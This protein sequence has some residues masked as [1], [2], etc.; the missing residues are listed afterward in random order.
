MSII[1]KCEGALVTVTMRMSCQLSLCSALVPSCLHKSK[2][3]PPSA[4][5]SL[6]ICL[7]ALR[8]WRCSPVTSKPSR[9][10]PLVASNTPTDSLL[11]MLW[12][13]LYYVRRGYFFSSSSCL[14]KYLDKAFSAQ[15]WT[16]RLLL[17]HLGKAKA[18]FNQDMRMT[19]FILC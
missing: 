9:W 6:L 10:Q 12:S 11:L 5:S 15:S 16:C 7:P 8:P 3:N 2:T 19:H 17:G 14:R 13:S 4:S 18:Y 1:Q